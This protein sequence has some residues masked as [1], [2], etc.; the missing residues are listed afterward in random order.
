MDDEYVSIA[1]SSISDNLYAVFEATDLGG[2][3]RDIHIARSTDGG[4]TVANDYFLPDGYNDYWPD[5]ALKGSTCYFIN[6][7]QDYYTGGVEVLV[8]ADA[9]AG[10]F[11]NVSYLSAWT[12]MDRRFPVLANDTD[13]VYMAFQLDYDDEQGTSDGDIVYCYSWD[14]LA[15]IYGPYE[16]VAD[17]FESV[18]PAI[19]VKDGVVGCLW[20]DAPPGGDEFYLAARQAGGSGHP[21]LWGD[22]EVAS[23]EPY[24][25]PTFHS[26]FGVAAGDRLHAAWID[27]RDYPTQGL[28]VYTCDRPVQPNLAPFTPDGWSGPLVAG[29][30]PGGR[31]TGWLAAD[32]TA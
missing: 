10:G 21:E 3:D 32:D 12:D 25:D 8:A 20:L 24:V 31:T 22:I 15:E 5:V 23:D 19:Y 11:G 14:G 27:R 29:M 17:E 7:G 6:T 18:G 2:A 13:K 4:E 28:N 16:M 26:A 9:L 30:A 1:A